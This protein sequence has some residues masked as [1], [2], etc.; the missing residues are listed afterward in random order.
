MNAMGEGHDQRRKVYL[1][2]QSSGRT[3]FDPRS[4]LPHIIHL[5][6]VY[7]HRNHWSRVSELYS[8]HVKEPEWLLWNSMSLCIGL[9]S[10]LSFLYAGYMYMCEYNDLTS[11][12][13]IETS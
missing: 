6:N 12:Y 11:L 8:G 4:W 9:M 5:F 1:L 3:G 13:S 2:V 7:I 10:L